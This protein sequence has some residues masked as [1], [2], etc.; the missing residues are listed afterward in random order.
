MKQLI[1]DVIATLVL[2]GV[3]LVAIGAVGLVVHS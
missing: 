1:G 3:F 2:F